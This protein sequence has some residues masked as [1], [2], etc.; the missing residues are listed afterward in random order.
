MKLKYTLL[1][2]IGLAFAAGVH[3]QITVGVTV[4]ATGPAASLGIPERNTVDLMPKEIAGQTMRYIV[5]DDQSD[6][7][8]A[9]MNIRRFVS[10]DRVDVVLG[11]TTTPN[12]LA[13]LDVAAESRTP[14]I[15]W[16]ASSQSHRYVASTSSAASATTAPTPR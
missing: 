3:A 11:S 5:L 2:A 16:A 8:H 4:S 15:S 9:V 10:E 6:T 12:S 13:M 1:A 14:M 7:T